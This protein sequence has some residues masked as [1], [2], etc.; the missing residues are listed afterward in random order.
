MKVSSTSQ[1]IF[2]SKT[3]VQGSTIWIELHM[4]V[5]PK[6][7]IRNILVRSK[8]QSE[9][10]SVSRIRFSYYAVSIP[11]RSY[12]SLGWGS[13][14]HV[15]MVKRRRP[16]YTAVWQRIMRIDDINELSTSTCELENDPDEPLSP[17]L[18]WRHHACD[19]S[20][21][22]LSGVDADFCFSLQQLSWVWAAFWM[23]RTTVE[24]LF[25]TV[26]L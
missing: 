20:C 7:Q 3:L 26:A 11:P 19:P 14:N 16:I 24:F 6:N 5:N 17:F 12:K 2:L 18:Q 9:Y 4:E 23:S 10:T 21:F 8:N 13:D 1:P 15:R 22:K 25:V